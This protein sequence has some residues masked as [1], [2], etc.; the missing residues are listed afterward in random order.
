MASFWKFSASEVSDSA[1]SVPESTS[2]GTSYTAASTSPRCASSSSARKR[3]LPAITAKVPRG[4]FAGV[5]IRFWMTPRAAISAASCSMK[6]SPAWR[7]LIGD[8]TSFAS[9]TL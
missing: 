1:A 2:T 5:T 7:T 8:S 4:F 3:R 6:S 9:F